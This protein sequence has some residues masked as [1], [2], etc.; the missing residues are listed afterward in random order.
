M[1]HLRQGARI[2]A[3]LAAGSELDT[4]P[5]LELARRRGWHV[6]V[7]IVVHARSAQMRFAP[8]DGELRVNRFGI[9]EPCSHP[10][11]WLAARWLDLV[12]VPLIAVGP[13]GERLGSGAGFYDR[14]FAHR[15]LRRTWHKP[16][17]VGL[18]YEC[19]RVP[20]LPLA[21]WDIALDALITERAFYRIGG[22]R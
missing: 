15:G 4:G 9:A 5:L 7:P 22:G 17:L 2:G 13:Y 16:P 11:A 3:Y 14:A 21:S 18:A 19:Q 20:S 1:V 10:S 8:L 6:Y 12:F